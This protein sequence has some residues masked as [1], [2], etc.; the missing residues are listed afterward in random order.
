MPALDKEEGG[1]FSRAPG[2][3][4]KPLSNSNSSPN[5]NPLGLS[6]PD[7]LTFCNPWSSGRTTDTGGW[8]DAGSNDTVSD[9][10]DGQWPAPVQQS[11]TDLVPEFEPGKPWKVRLPTRVVLTQF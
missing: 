1:E 7:G 3:I 11:L 2:S 10:K 6:Q 8:P 5:L 9:N 4:S